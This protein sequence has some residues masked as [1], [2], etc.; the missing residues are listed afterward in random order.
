[1]NLAVPAAVR[2]A[3]TANASMCSVFLTRA[4][5][6]SSGESKRRNLAQQ[7]HA[8]TFAYNPATLQKRLL[9]AQSSVSARFSQLEEKAS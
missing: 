6:G 3:L 8:T 5:S 7:R 9:Q 2:R 1:M 4:V